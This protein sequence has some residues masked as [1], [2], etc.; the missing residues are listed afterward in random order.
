M[1]DYSFRCTYHLIDDEEQ[2]DVLYQLQFLQACG[3]TDWNDTKIN[4]ICSE[5][6]DKFRNNEKGLKIL[7][8][9]IKWN[10]LSFLSANDNSMVAVMLCCYDL[11]NF[12][13]DCMI[14]FFTINDISDE[15]YNKLMTKL[16][17]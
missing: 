12:T 16:E 8:A 3:L 7:D 4:E 10:P 5:I 2:S 17:N 14:D 6:Y 9:C 15:N 13:H 11:F 1:Y